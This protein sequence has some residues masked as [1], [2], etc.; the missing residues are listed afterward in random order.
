MSV[1]LQQDCQIIHIL[2]GSGES[3]QTGCVCSQ[4]RP[5]HRFPEWIEFL[6]QFRWKK[7]D[8]R[9]HARHWETSNYLRGTHT[10]IRER[11]HIPLIGSSI[12]ITSLLLGFV[13]H[14]YH[15]PAKHYG[16]ACR[17]ELYERYGCWFTCLNCRCSYSQ[18]TPVS[19]YL[20]I[21]QEIWQ[22]HQQLDL[23]LLLTNRFINTL[24]NTCE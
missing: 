17:L 6:W 8:A 16:Q 18:N 21:H 20:L 2:W 7:L 23:Q 3:V 15:W 9:G 24:M 10:Q 13:C 22:I 11:N 14:H 5:W 1:Q 19:S 12:H 4:Y